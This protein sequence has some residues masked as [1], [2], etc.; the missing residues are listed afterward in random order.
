MQ[1]VQAAPVD[2][3]VLSFIAGKKMKKIILALLFV[4]S[5][6]FAWQQQAPKAV[7]ACDSMAPYGWPSNGK[8][9]VL[10]EAIQETEATV[11]PVVEGAVVVGQLLVLVL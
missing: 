11:L 5:S 7:E 3:A 4:S 8:G 2:A 10:Q 1:A 9:T 6:V